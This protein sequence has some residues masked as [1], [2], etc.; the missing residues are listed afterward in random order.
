MQTLTR[1]PSSMLAASINDWEG[2]RSR[3]WLILADLY[4]LLA[5]VHTKKPKPYPRPWPDPGS[6]RR[7]HTDL[8]RGKVI[9]LLNAH[10]HSIPTE[11]DPHG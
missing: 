6:R 8:P 9:Q 2:P 10:G 4:D 11:V 3:E 7:G 5:V 1:D